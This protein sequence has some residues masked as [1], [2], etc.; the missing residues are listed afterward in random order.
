MVTKQNI[1]SARIMRTFYKANN[2]C[3]CIYE[4]TCLAIWTN[5]CEHTCSSSLYPPAIVEHVRQGIPAFHF[6]EQV[7]FADEQSS[8]SRL[9]YQL[10]SV[11]L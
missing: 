7:T 2:N 4:Y 1:L 3:L 5:K 10:Q 11:L 9:V 6:Y 8:L